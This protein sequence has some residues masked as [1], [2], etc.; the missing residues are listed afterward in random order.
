[1]T[2]PSTPT[3][4]SSPSGYAL[5]DPP[6]PIRGG[7]AEE[8]S[9]GERFYAA[10]PLFLVGVACVV[11]AILL[12]PNGIATSWGGNGSVRL[13]PWIL[14]L[15]LGITGISSGTVALF[16]DDMLETPRPVT[17]GAASPSGVQ[18]PT[19]TRQW[20]SLGP[21]RRRSGSKPS[22]ERVTPRAV[23]RA[24]MASGRTAGPPVSAPRP[25]S[26]APIWDESAIEGGGE[27]PRDQDDWSEDEA[28]PDALLKERSSSGAVLR[29]LDELELSLRKR[30]PP[31]APK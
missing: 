23:P 25:E 24:S 9:W 6:G 21:H 17:M 7:S 15:A 30:S 14:F 31:A 2:A 26:S 4:S 11:V 22:V 13:R 12:D 27:A 5:V 20:F 3:A 18:E 29:Q 10:L 28:V 8:E 16:A 1:M 19:A